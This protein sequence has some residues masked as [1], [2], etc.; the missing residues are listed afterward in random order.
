MEKAPLGIRNHIA[1]RA[2]EYIHDIVSLQGTYMITAEIVM[3]ISNSPKAP[4]PRASPDS[5]DLV[6]CPCLVRKLQSIELDFRRIL[7]LQI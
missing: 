5:P 7:A 1:W 4:R 2:E 3:T 6:A